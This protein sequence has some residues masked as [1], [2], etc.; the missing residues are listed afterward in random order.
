MKNH[1]DRKNYNWI[2]SLMRSESPIFRRPE[3]KSSCPYATIVCL[4]LCL[5]ISARLYIRHGNS[6][7]IED[8]HSKYHTYKEIQDF[9]QSLEK[10]H[11]RKV[12]LELIGHSY[13]SRAIYAVR[14]GKND[15][16]K[17]LENFLMKNS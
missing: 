3:E 13:Q 15:Q 1:I 11:A 12:S 9:I 2:Y 6:A 7:R 4:T 5:F 17:V 10:S 16:Y 14:I 8:F